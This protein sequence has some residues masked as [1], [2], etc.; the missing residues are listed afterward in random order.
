MPGIL[1]RGVSI[2]SRAVDTGARTT[3]GAPVSILDQ[4]LDGLFMPFTR[5][6]RKLARLI[7]EGERL[8]GVLDAVRIVAAGG[9]G[10]EHY[11]GVTVQGPHGE[12]RAGVRQQLFLSYGARARLGAEVIVLHLDGKVAVDWPGTMRLD[13]VELPGN[14]AV[15][16]GKTTKEPIPAGIRDDMLDRKKLRTWPASTGELLAVA[17]REV[18][19]MPV[20]EKRVTLRLADGSEIERSREHV[21][22]YARHLAR[23][24]VTVPVVENPKKP[25]DV[26]IDWARAAEEDAGIVGPASAGDR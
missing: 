9:D 22:V 24:G 16:A 15:I 8:P 17:D 14:P 6:D 21:P 26:R 12:F 5:T 7:R 2:P 4:A 3:Y 19:G 10:S 1:G 18:M 20:Q 11:L 25:G 23:P 13:G